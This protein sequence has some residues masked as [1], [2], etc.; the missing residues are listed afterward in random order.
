MGPFASARRDR[1]AR[2]RHRAGLLAGAVLGVLALLAPGTAGAVEFTYPP[3]ATGATRTAEGFELKGTVYDYASG[4]TTSWHFE[5]GTTSGYGTSLPLPEGETTAIAMP[6]SVQITG[7]AADTT[8]HWRLVSNNPTEGMLATP[9]QTFSTAITT[10]MPPASGGG[11]G[12]TGTGL[13]PTP[14]GN[15]GAGSTPPPTVAG[16]GP[17]RVAK[18]LGHGG[19]TLLTTTGGR[20][21]YALS[22]E[23]KGKFLCT[24]ESGCTE[25]WHPL[26][27]APGVTPEGPVKL[28]TTRRPEG[29]LQVT[30]RG[31]PL[32]TFGS[33]KKPGQVKGEGLKDVGVWHAV[34]VP[35]PK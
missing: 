14:G 25:I 12:E 23:H 31:K 11:A 34:F 20:T 15:S 18:T 33:D 16:K 29:T 35:T 19:R 22:A 7:L 32:Y 10:T 28:G 3:H 9:D 27:V 5:Y 4:T 30:Y 6:V 8:Y 2:H 1:T 13:Y 26:T 17:K 21:L 24:E